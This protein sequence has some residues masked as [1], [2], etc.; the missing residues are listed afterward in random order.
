MNHTKYIC[1]CIGVMMLCACGQQ[2][3]QLAGNTG[4]EIEIFPDYKEV[5]I[6]VNIAPLNFN[7]ESDATHQLIIEGADGSAAMQVRANDGLFD[8]PAGKWQT[9]LQANAGKALTLTVARLESDGKWYGYQP[10]QINVAA[11][12]I[13]PYMAYRLIPPYEQ[14]NRMGIYQRNLESYEQTAIYENKLTDYNCVNCHTF[15]NQDPQQMIFHMRAKSPG[16]VLIDHGNISKLNTKTDET[17]SNLV[18]PYWHPSGKFI[19]ASV[20]NTLQSYYYN[21]HD[22]VEVYDSGSDVVVYDVERHEIF[23]NDA[24]KSDTA[25]ESFPTFSP[26]GRTLYYT[27]ANAV[28]SVEQHIDR[29]RYSLCRI[30]FDPD[31]RQLGNHVDTLFNAQTQGRSISHPRIS[32]DGRLMVVCLQGYGNFSATNKDADLYAINLQSGEMYPLS[33]ANSDRADSWHSWSG[34]SRWLAFN[35]R[36]ADGYYSRPYFTYI[37]QDGQARKP[38]MLPQKNPKKFYNDLMFSYN[39]PELI[40]GKVTTNAHRIVETMN[41]TPGIDAKYRK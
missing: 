33:A 19:A 21:N 31:T 23:S 22:R 7:I 6:P 18:Y 2:N 10:F 35:S 4:E 24:L 27:T 3:I 13:E 20:N 12:S 5:T 16:T 41:E 37:G 30:D 25:Y 29:V 14:W 28:D 32:P 36:R 11:D 40:H 1:A 8:I 9:L 34:N 38:F 15:R 17:L 26:D 39:L